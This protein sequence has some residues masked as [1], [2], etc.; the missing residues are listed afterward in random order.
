MANHTQLA[1]SLMN[2]NT[3]DDFDP[4]ERPKDRF[5]NP[6][7]IPITERSK[8]IVEEAVRMLENYESHLNLRKRKRKPSDQAIFEETVSAVL[9]DV[10]HHHLSNEPGGL[11][12][13]R[14]NSV[15]GRKSRYRP[16]AY[17][18]T[19]PNILDR[20]EKPEMAFVTEKIGYEG[21]FGRGQQTVIAAA[22]STTARIKKHDIELSDFGVSNNR[23]VIVL[24]SAKSG[25]WDE[26]DDL[27]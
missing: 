11:A 19:L 24:R 10:M 14:S 15:L 27:E 3:E 16:R 4:E 26:S 13:T 5:F 6:W 7:R 23:E 17:S 22:A 1:Q 8:A 20:M 25:F 9:C 18:K 12:I 21:H 2:E